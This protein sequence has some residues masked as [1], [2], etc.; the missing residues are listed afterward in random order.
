MVFKHY[1]AILNRFDSLTDKHKSKMLKRLNNYLQYRYLK[2]LKNKI[3]IS[4]P[5]NISFFNE[6][7]NRIFK[8]V[9]KL[10]DA[11]LQNEYLTLFKLF[12]KNKAEIAQLE[13]VV[14]VR[15]TGKQ[16]YGTVNVIMNN[17]EYG[18]YPVIGICEVYEL[19]PMDR[20]IL[21]E[22]RKKNDLPTIEDYIN[23]MYVKYRK[24][25]KYQIYNNNVKTIGLNYE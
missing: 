20:M 15:N 23:E 6:N 12:V 3:T 16:M 10:N 4:K 11:V 25:I 1:L 21:N 8:F 24:I 5:Q 19:T 17:R 18:F 9:V 2:K 13:D 7:S 14:L 22:R